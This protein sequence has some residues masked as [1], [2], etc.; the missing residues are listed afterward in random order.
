MTTSAI[1]AIAIIA[2]LVIF[3]IITFN[4]LIVNRNNVDNAFAAI[5]VQLK[6]R[7]DLIPN[8]VSAVKTYMTHESQTLTQIA[9]LRSQAINP[10][11]S[12]TEKVALNNQISSALRNIMVQVERYPNLKADQSFLHLQR[13]LNEIEEQ[14]SAARR[15]YNAAVT[16]FNN[17]I[18]MFPTSIFANILG[19]RPR[20]LFTITEA[21]RAVPN[22]G[23]LFN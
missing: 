16:H 22:V 7:C 10:N 9:Q 1:V 14:L 21:E 18:Q 11:L 4:T 5:D 12:A 15:S 20:E 23:Q 17:S 2:I 6:K 3:I 8:L 13:T 19:F